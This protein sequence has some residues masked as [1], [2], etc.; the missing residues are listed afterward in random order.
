VPKRDSEA[1][2]RRLIEAVARNLYGAVCDTTWIPSDEPDVF[3]WAD[4]HPARI[5][6]IQRPEMSW[7]VWREQ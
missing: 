1:D 7:V 4:G 5:L 3:E 2:H 6:K